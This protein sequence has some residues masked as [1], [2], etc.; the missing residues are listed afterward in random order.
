MPVRVFPGNVRH[1]P[2]TA[3]D[4]VEAF[5]RALDLQ[6]G[7]SA[8]T[9]RAYVGDVTSLLRGLLA[10]GTGSDGETGADPLD[11]EIVLDEALD[12]SALR[13]WLA[14]QTRSGAAR[15]SI[16][17]RAAAAR[18]F[19][20]WAHD[21]GHLALDVGAR[22]LS[23]RPESRV[24]QVLSV[25]GVEAMLDAAAHAARISDGDPVTLR[26]VAVLELLYATGVRVSELA[27]ADID[28]ADRRERILRVMGKG[29]KERV[30]PFGIPAARALEE[31]LERGRPELLATSSPPALFLGVRGGRMGTRAVREVVH[32]HAALGG[33]DVAPHGVRHST[34]THLLSGGSDLRT[35]QEVLGHASLATTQRYTH[36]SDERLRAAYRQ[37]HP[38]A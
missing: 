30:V 18:T 11:V 8:H 14:W 20:A 22:L 19:S 21:E 17:R 25:D 24:P 27:A 2:V 37:A 12:I 5:S 7:Y 32:R 9:V 29:G 34:A 16:A 6:R 35:V 28:D 26:D 3:R 38:R 31:W 13:R 36:I 10:A 4:L 23:P 33:A 15:S 1:V